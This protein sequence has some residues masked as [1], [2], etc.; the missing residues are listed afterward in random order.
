MCSRKKRKCSKLQNFTAASAVYIQPSRPVQSNHMSNV[1]NVLLPF[2]YVR[3]T[4]QRCQASKMHQL[5]NLMIQPYAFPPKMHPNPPL[6]FL[7][8]PLPPNGVNIFPYPPPSFSPNPPPQSHPSLPPS[9]LQPPLQTPM[10]NP[11]A[12]LP[13]L[14]PPQ[15]PFPLLLPNLIKPPLLLHIRRP[16]LHR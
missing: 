3:P 15:R 7:Q 16:I 6:K 4:L 11:G 2:P 5:S 1:P 14:Q 13:S 8:F 12:L 10:I 9:T